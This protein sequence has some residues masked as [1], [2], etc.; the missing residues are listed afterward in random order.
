[1]SVPSTVL[2]LTAYEV[3]RVHRVHSHEQARQLFCCRLLPGRSRGYA[4]DGGSLLVCAPAQRG[5]D[6]L[7][8]RWALSHQWASFVAGDCSSFKDALP[9]G[10]GFIFMDQEIVFTICDRC[11][12]RC[13]FESYSERSKV[14]CPNARMNTGC[15]LHK[16]DAA[17]S[18]APRL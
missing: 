8:K 10:S 1:M 2:Y 17:A 15:A 6:E 12:V 13:S 5:R 18:D 14:L 9:L 3:S 7:N 16:P 11:I 4:A